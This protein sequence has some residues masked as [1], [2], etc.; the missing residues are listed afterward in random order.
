MTEQ[1][2]GR[3]ARISPFQ[4]LLDFDK[5]E[6]SEGYARFTLKLQDKHMNHAGIPHGGVYSALLDNALGASGCYKGSD[7]DMRIAVTLNLNVS[8]LAQ[9]EGQ[10]LTVQGRV[11]G[12][13]RKIYFAEGDVADDTG[14]VLA[15]ATG[16]FRL[17]GTG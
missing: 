17:L 12:G 14:K 15:R 9:P 3:F 5:T 10:V 6:F 8:Y 11:V 2:P 7:T 4:E 1:P 16:T 13:G